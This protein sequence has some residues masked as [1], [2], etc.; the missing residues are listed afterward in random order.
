MVCPKCNG[1]TDN[2]KCLSVR[3]SGGFTVHWRCFRNQCGYSGNPRGASPALL[4]KHYKE[5]RYYTR[6]YEALENQQEK[7][8]YDQFGFIP[9]D[10]SYNKETDRFIFPVHGPGFNDNRGFIARSFSGDSPKTITYNETP[11]LP[12]VHYAG[13]RGPLVI[14]E[15]WIS[16]EKITD[17]GWG[18]GVA[19]NGTY[20]SSDALTEIATQ[21]LPESH[22]CIALDKDAFPQSIR[23]FNQLQRMLPEVCLW[24]L[25]K[26]LKYVSTS[27]IR[28]AILAGMGGFDFTDEE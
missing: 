2:E 25:D 20:A 8:L 7:W 4:S 27:R 5:P 19:L 3:V 1:G 21:V 14:V 10:A 16:A 6:P 9:R 11:E 13:Q 26:D 24:R 28:S 17:S 15:D 18:Q 12:F 23:L 22:I